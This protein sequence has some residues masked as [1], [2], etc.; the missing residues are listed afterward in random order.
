MVRSLMFQSGLPKHFFGESILTATYIINRLPS[1]LL[2]WKSSFE[3]LHN[4]APSVQHLRTFGSLCFITNTVPHKEKFAPRS[5]PAIFLGQKPIGC[6]W[7]YKVKC[8]PTWEVD[9]HKARLVANGYNQ[10]EGIDYFDNF[11]LV[12]KTVTVRMVLAIVVAKSWHL[13]QLDIN[14]AFLDGYLDEDIYMT[15]RDGYQKEK[16]GQMCKLIR[17]LYGLKQESRQ[18]NHEFTLNIATYGFKQSP[19]DHC[20][21]IIHKPDCFMVL[22]VYVDDILLASSSKLE[23]QK[24]KDF[25]HD[26][27]TIK[28]LGVAKYFLGIEIARTTAG[29]Y[30]TQRKYNTYIIADMKLT[31]ANTTQTPFL[32]DWNPN[33]EN[34]GPCDDPSAYR[35]YNLYC[36]YT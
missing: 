13:H 28:D 24:I 31:E 11:S 5:Y 14:N 21:F 25:L 6:K 17:S 22:V 2:H 7:V 30:V 26:K 32:S 19:Y 27:F 4:S 23:I 3:L 36:K 15:P 12:A 8:K 20:L 33:D 1:Y 16:E 34:S 29:M 9:K 35:R 10:I 18:W